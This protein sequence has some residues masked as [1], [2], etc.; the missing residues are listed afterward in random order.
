MECYRLRLLL[1]CI[2]ASSLLGEVVSLLR[3]VAA[4]ERAISLLRKVVIF[5]G[6]RKESLKEG[7][8]PSDCG[9]A[10]KEDLVEEP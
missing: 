7:R 2:S 9:W 8:D 6:A 4:V 10:V 5:I 3:R 1:L